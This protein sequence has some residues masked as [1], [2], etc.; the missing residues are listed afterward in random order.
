MISTHEEAPAQA[1]TGLRTLLVDDHRTFAQ[2][3]R[4]RLRAHPGFDPVEVAYSGPEA[5]ALASALEPDLVL[6][7]AWL[8]DVA[9]IPVIRALRAAQPQPVVVMLSGREEPE[10]IIEALQEGAS[11]WVPKDAAMED[12]LGA[13]AVTLTGRRWLPPALLGPVLELLMSR[14]AATAQPETFLDELTPRQRD[15]LDCLTQ[16]MSRSQIAEHLV[17]SPHTVRTHV[18]ELFRKA[19]VHSTLALL[20]RAREAAVH[21]GGTRRP[22]P[23]DHPGR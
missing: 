1:V 12:L 15:V 8:G 17:L 13:V 21:G 3:L 14:P 7:D 2:A 22:V 19:D 10:E 6:L 23:P 16:G 11:G 20:A 5:L 9:A 4:A 18:Q